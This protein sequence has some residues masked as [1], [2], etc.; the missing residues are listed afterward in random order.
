MVGDRQDLAPF[1]ER[2]FGLAL[3]LV[4]LPEQAMRRRALLV[5]G[6]HRPRLLHRGGEQIVVEQDLGQPEV[7]G[8]GRDRAVAQRRPGAAR[9]VFSAG[10]ELRLPEADDGGRAGRLPAAKTLPDG[11]RPFVIAGALGAFGQGLQ[12][13]RL[14]REM[15]AGPIERRAGRG[16]IAGGQLAVDELGGEPDIVGNSTLKVGQGDDRLFVA[17]ESVEK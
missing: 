15:E 1:V 7:P 12:G 3:S 14:V 2:R 17:T 16:P 4:D 11:H 9:V 5:E 13:V 8:R 6:Q 10:L